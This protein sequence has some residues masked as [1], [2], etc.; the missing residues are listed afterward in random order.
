MMA[1]F[2]FSINRSYIIVPSFSSYF[3]FLLF[4]NDSSYVWYYLYVRNRNKDICLFKMKVSQSKYYMKY[5]GTV[6]NKNPLAWEYF[7]Q[8][9]KV[10]SCGIFQHIFYWLT[11]SDHSLNVM[12][13]ICRFFSPWFIPALINDPPFYCTVN[14]CCFRLVDPCV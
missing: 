8:I 7:S 12:N 2:W 3:N 6:W 13:V 11:K 10:F 14:L 5:G 9:V 1:I 4:Y